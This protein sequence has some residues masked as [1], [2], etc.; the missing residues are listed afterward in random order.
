ME[1][2]TQFTVTLD[3]NG[4][5]GE[6]KT[7][8][9]DAGKS[10]TLPE[11]V[12]TRTGYKFLGWNTKDDGS[13]DF[14]YETTFTPV[15]DLT[16]YAQWEDENTVHILLIPNKGESDAS[17]YVSLTGLRGETLTLSN[18]FTWDGHQFTG[19]NENEDGSGEI[20]YADGETITLDESLMLY[21]QW[22]KTT[23]DPETVTV[24]LD[25]NNGSE[26]TRNVDGTANVDLT[27]P[28]NPFK[29]E[30]YHFTGWNT[31]ANG[32][33]TAYA[34]KATV[35]TAENITLYAQWKVAG[36]YTVTFRANGGTG[37][38]NDETVTEGDS[39]ILPE[40]G[41]TGPSTM[42]VFAG[43]IV[44]G[45]DNPLQP[46][47]QIAVTGNVTVRANWAAKNGCYVATAVYGSYDCPEVWT[48]RRFRDKVLAKTW[49]GRL[50]IRLYYAVSPTAVRLFGETTWFQDFWRGHLDTM[51]GNLQA[52]GFEST[53]Y[54]DRPW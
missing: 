42:P 2:G 46:G 27:L 35:N 10:F 5:S 7:Y 13:G 14:Y 52:N 29:R 26:E 39:L 38:M 30:G 37:E 11:N 17:E 33:G 20:K 18:S 8:S 34:D 32:N 9:V 23:T 4:A 49:Y 41:F 50:F 47:A 54:Q 40:N 15:E 31:D 1:T 25:A 3:P 12:F 44:P 51:V 53:P 36:T 6:A 16:L 19:W 45:Y 43:W 48:L 22:E 28:A 24:T 21:A